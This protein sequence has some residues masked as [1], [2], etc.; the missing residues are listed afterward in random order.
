MPDIYADIATALRDRGYDAESVRSR[1][2][3][4]CVRVAIP[5][6]N[7]WAWWGIAD[8]RWGMVVYLG[9]GQLVQIGEL[10]TNMEVTTTD[11]EKIAM[12]IALEMDEAE[13]D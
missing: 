4:C 10:M 7:L 9:A 2:D 5:Y 1:Q 13:L 11:V 3:T 6:S 12:R 8:D